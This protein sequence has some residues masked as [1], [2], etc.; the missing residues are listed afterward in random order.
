MRPPPGGV[1]LRGLCESFQDQ[2]AAG[3]LALKLD[4]GPVQ[5][6]GLGIAYKSALDIGEELN[7]GRLVPL[8]TEWQGEPSPLNLLCADRRQL[9]PA[10]QALYAFLSECCRQD[11]K[12][13][14]GDSTDDVPATGHQETGVLFLFPVVIPARVLLRLLPFFLEQAGVVHPVNGRER[15]LPGFGDLEGPAVS[16]IE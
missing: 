11:T 13:G 7:D 8:C 6:G 10:V 4:V 12:T 1:T 16:I 15:L 5:A 9:N 2:L 3:T 14:Q